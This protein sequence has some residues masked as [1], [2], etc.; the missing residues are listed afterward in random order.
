[1]NIGKLLLLFIFT[2]NII[3]C[4]VIS[5]ELANNKID[6]KNLNKIDIKWQ[7]DYLYSNPENSFMPG[8][9]NNIIF[10]SDYK[11]NLYRIDETDGSIILKYQLNKNLSS[12]TA[13]SSSKIF[14]TSTD[15]YLLAVDRGSGKLI[16][17]AQLPT[18]SI[19]PPQAYNNSVLVKTNDDQLLAYDVDS[20]QL[21]W[22]YQG[23]TPSLTLR[24]FNSFQV[25]GPQV[26]LFGQAGG[27]LA[28]LNLSTGLVIWDNYITIPK[29]ATDLD[30]LTDVSGRPVLNQ[31]E[32]CVA[33][34]NGKISCIDILS[35]NIL[36]SMDFSTIY[37]ISIDENNL[38]A[39]NTDGV[40]YCFNSLN[41]KVLW[42]NESFKDK[43]LNSPIVLNDLI[44]IIDDDGNVFGLRK[45]DG[46]II[47]YAKSTLKDGVS[48]IPINNSIILQSVSGTLAIIT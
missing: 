10:T 26:V 1:M 11:G 20:G 44:L 21:L 12:G 3:S 23:Q 25:I 16:W 43:D 19:E 41:G 4:S 40:V 29:G 30:K 39:I 38:F 37:G 47:S 27:K 14:V 2:F 24:I 9:D 8:I 46:K 34:Y 28:L 13:V 6:T 48:Y 33:T 31:K 5:N 35:D 36:W 45:T 17:Q 18:I 42:R 7:K 22:V 32:T 15:G